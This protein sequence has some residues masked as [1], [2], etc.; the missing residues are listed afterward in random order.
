MVET[1]QKNGFCSKK[2]RKKEINKE[3]KKHE[4]VPRDK[5]KK[6]KKEKNYTEGNKRE[7]KTQARK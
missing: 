3:R 4:I 1:C 6:I 2:E 5:Q 7:I